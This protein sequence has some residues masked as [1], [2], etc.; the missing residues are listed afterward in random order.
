MKMKMS[1]SF[2]YAGIAAVVCLVIYLLVKRFTKA[3][4]N[5]R[6]T[7]PGT[8]N[9]HQFPVFDGCPVVSV[10]PPCLKLETFLR[11]A[12]IPYKNEYG[13]KFSKKGKMPWIE[14]NGQEVADSNFCIQFL[15]KEL[16]VDID[17]HLSA[18]EKAIAHSVR[19]MLEENTFWTMIYCRWCSDYAP[20]F[21]E[22]LFP[23]LFLPVKYL[24]FKIFQ[25]RYRKYMWSHGIGRHSEQDLYG[26]GEKDL[27][28]A[29]E[30]LG[31][32]KFLFGEKPCLAD[33]ALFA[34]IAG[35]TWDC[36]ESPHA[37]LT[38]SKAKNLDEHAKRMKELYY[39]DWDEIISKKHKSGHVIFVFL[40]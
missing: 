20:M 29:S 7:K 31:H 15:K 10:S 23:K 33:A 28:A 3:K 25:R 27:L 6:P 36:P 40:N 26:I 11:M 32:K 17:S 30:V 9:L 22:K 34:F 24:V 37:L 14:F 39:P 12:K 1:A 35:F 38:K 8:V 19:T 4:K 18:R 21:R 13:F 16:Q 2:L 5:K